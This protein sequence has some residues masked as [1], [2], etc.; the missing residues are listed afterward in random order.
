MSFYSTGQVT[1]RLWHL[2]LFRYQAWFLSNQPA[3]LPLT[4]S[5]REPAYDTSRTGQTKINPGQISAWGNFNESNK[6]MWAKKNAA[7]FCSKQFCLV[8]VERS[9]QISFKAG[10]ISGIIPTPS[11]YSNKSEAQRLNDLVQGH[12]IGSK[13]VARTLVSKLPGQISFYYII[14]PL[15][16][17]KKKWKVWRVIF[18]HKLNQL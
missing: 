11:L 13:A 15:G 12:T 14:L 7:G 1:F 18:F 9:H 8:Q 2:F 5:I 3:P 10:I 17:L 16:G 4:S 6:N